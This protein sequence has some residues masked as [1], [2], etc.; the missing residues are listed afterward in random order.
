MRRYTCGSDCRPHVCMC[1]ASCMHASMDVA[2]GPKL[3]MLAQP[4]QHSSTAQHF[5]YT[6]RCFSSF[7]A[8]QAADCPLQVHSKLTVL[9]VFCTAERHLDTRCCC[10][11]LLL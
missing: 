11:L 4:R 7:P 5:Q 8:Q 3:D 2:S 9:K 1:I 10:V 6:A